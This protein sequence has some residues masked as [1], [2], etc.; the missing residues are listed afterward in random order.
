[1]MLLFLLAHRLLS[2]QWTFQQDDSP[3]VILDGFARPLGADTPARYK[4]VLGALASSSKWELALEILREMKRAG[5]KP[6]IS[7][8]NHALRALETCAPEKGGS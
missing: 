5:V 6:R 3:K 7:C 4:C 2:Q 1:M 8:F